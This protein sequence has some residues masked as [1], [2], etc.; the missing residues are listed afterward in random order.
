MGFDSGTMT[1]RVYE[2]REAIGTEIIQLFA[3]N[4]APPIKSLGRDAI[5]GWVGPRHL[6]D[7]DITEANCLISGYVCVTLMKAERKIPEALLRA[8]CRL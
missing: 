3:K 8:T 2:I 7:T 5:T 6:L 1:F 4:V